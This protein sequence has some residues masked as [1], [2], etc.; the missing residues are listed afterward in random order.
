MHN[1]VFIYYV[2]IAL[3]ELYW[4]NSRTKTRLMV[5]F[6]SRADNHGDKENH[7][8]LW[9]CEFSAA[10]PIKTLIQPVKALT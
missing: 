3:E 7:I 2:P 4:D 9:K 1:N 8:T 5:C 6:I 10:P